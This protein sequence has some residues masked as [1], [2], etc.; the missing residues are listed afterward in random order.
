MSDTTCWKCGA[1]LQDNPRSFSFCKD[2]LLGTSHTRLNTFNIFSLLKSSPDKVLL[3]VG[4]LLI[5]SLSMS[6]AWLFGYPR[7]PTPE[8]LEAVNRT[9]TD[10]CN[11][12]Q[13]CVVVYLAPWCGACQS[14]LPWIGELQNAALST[15]GVRFMIVVGSDERANLLGMARQLPQGAFLD[16][17]GVYKSSLGVY[18]FPSFFLVD[19]ERQVL[20]HFRPYYE[21]DDLSPGK[22]KSFVSLNLPED[23]QNS[24][25]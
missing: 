3:F 14:E 23:A 17:K 1:P 13:Y 7:L 2:C 8:V 22:L 10:P 18:A 19:H 9:N 4:A 25:R 15:K 6:P 12:A 16:A 11:A 20:K 24:L 21:P 5:I